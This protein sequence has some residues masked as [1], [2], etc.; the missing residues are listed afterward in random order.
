MSRTNT[1][2][3]VSNAY[4]PSVDRSLPRSAQQATG[5]SATID[6]P[7]AEAERREVPGLIRVGAQVAES[8]GPAGAIVGGIADLVDGGSGASDPRSAQMDAMW[9]MQR[10]SQAFNLEY[11]ALQE[12]I[13]AENR[14]FTTVSNLLKARHETSKAAIQNIRA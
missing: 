2:S 11:L 7:R 1:T 14:N 13:Q 4:F 8:F 6:R 10:E 3:P 12:S 5:F 9:D